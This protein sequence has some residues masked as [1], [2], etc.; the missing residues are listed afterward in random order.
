ML[1]RRLAHI[2]KC[3]GAAPRW[4]FLQGTITRQFV[5]QK[6]IMKW[7]RGLRNEEVPLPGIDLHRDHQINRL[8]YW[9]NSCRTF[10]S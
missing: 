7:Y 9:K 6:K 8:L 1:R 3:Y 10:N 2:P 5:I 4:L